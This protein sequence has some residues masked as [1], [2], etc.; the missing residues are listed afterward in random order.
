MNQQVGRLGEQLVAKHFVEKGGRILG[1]NVSYPCGEIDLIV[2]LGTEVVF[3]EVKTRSTLAFGSAE[4]ITPSKFHR[5][6]RAAAQWLNGQPLRNV[7][8]D[9]VVVDLSADEEITHYEGIECG[10]R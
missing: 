7:R 5:M 3:V 8:F 2:E 10:A 6:K 9:A 1:R 4:A